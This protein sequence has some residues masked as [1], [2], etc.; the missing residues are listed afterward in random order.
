MRHEETCG[1]LIGKEISDNISGHHWKEGIRIELRL[2]L[3]SKVIWAG[4][5]KTNER[6]VK[7]QFRA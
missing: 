3:E 6:W 4:C 1:I 7:S 2:K 5:L